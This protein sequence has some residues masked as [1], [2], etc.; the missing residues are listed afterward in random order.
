MLTYYIWTE[1]YYSKKEYEEYNFCRVYPYKFRLFVCILFTLF[2]ILI[3]LIAWP[4]ELIFWL[5][6]TFLDM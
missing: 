5:V 2:A 3:D 4:L 1:K 6:Q